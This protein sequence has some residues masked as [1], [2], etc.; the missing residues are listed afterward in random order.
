MEYD[1]L[2][3]TETGSTLKAEA[4][5]ISARKNSQILRQGVRRFE[6]GHLY[7]T[8]RLGPASIERLIADTNEWGGSGI[9]HDYGLA[10]AH[11]EARAGIS[12][13]ENTLSQFEEGL[14]RLNSQF[15]EFVFTGRCTIQN[16]TTELKSSY[17]LD[18]TT[19][20]GL[21]E[22]YFLYQRKGSSNMMDG[23]F[24]ETSAQSEIDKAIT[25]H[26]DFLRAQGR[27]V[28]LKSGRMPVL[29]VDGLQP[30]DK[31][32]ESF[33][34][35]K[36]E[37][38]SSLYSGKLGQKL[39]SNK[40]TITDNAYD[41][42]NGNFDFFDGEG[43]VR[44]NDLKL[45]DQGNFS[46]LLSDLR[47]GKKFSRPSTGNGMRSYNKGIQLSPRSLRV[48]GGLESWK[49]IVKRLDRCLVAMIAA[50]GDSND[51][52]EFSSPVQVGYILEKGEVIGQAPQVTIKTSVSNYLG[53][54]LIDVSSDGFTAS[55]PSACVI[56]EM[57]VFVN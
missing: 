52:G 32:I 51:L 57:D 42:I 2:S 45:V 12:L 37:D 26:A 8:S 31:L 35:N 7:Q 41:P 49:S 43:I 36:Y 22:W 30:A 33:A 6:K 53:S 13:N 55:S 11:R 21:C 3:I 38:G 20:G 23:Y 47:F 25:E 27:I 15:P 19:S 39:F 46:G 9:R 14:D 44:A 5:R 54:H 50:G 34:I 24:G 28:T 29:F 1:I 4:G 17:G 16:Q 10:P 40:I 18:L 56:S 48:S